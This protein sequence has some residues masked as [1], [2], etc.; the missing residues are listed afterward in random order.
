MSLLTE[1]DLAPLKGERRAAQ[2]TVF[3]PL[4]SCSIKVPVFCRQPVAISLSGEMD[5]VT[6]S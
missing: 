3:W 5:F 1:R 4:S 2:K 6:P